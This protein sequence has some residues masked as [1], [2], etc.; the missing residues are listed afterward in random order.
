M[1]NAS[2][3]SDYSFPY[4]IIILSIIANAVH[5]AVELDQV[6]QNFSYLFLVIFFPTV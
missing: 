1:Y 5:F 2:I 3:F 6:N 4:I